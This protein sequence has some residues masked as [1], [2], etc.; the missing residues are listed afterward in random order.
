MK[1]H[2][3][4]LCATATL[5]SPV[6]AQIFVEKVFQVNQTIPDYGQYVDVHTLSEFGMASILDVSVELKLQ[7]AAGSTMRLGDYFVSLTY[8]TASEEERVAVLLNRPRA[9]DTR[10]W[11]SSLGS[12]DLRFD[13]SV[14]APNVFG[15]TSTT[16]TYAADGRLSVDPYASPAAYNAGAVTHGLASLN[17][18][19]LAS[20]TWSLLV[21]DAW[22]GG[23]GM[24]SSWKL[25]I[26]G[27]AAES[28]TLDPGLGGSIGDV[29]GSGIQEVKAGLQ[30][31][32]KGVDS[33]TANVS[34]NLVLSGGLSGAGH[35]LKNG[36]G[37]LTLGGDSSGFTGSVNLY[38]GALR[39][40]SSEAL[41]AIAKLQVSGSGSI[42]NLANSSR[43]DAPVSLQ[44]Y[45]TVLVLDGAG[46]L[47]GAITGEGGL[48]KVGSG[49]TFLAGDSNLGGGVAVEEGILSV[50]GRISG[51]GELRIFSGAT[52]KGS[53]TINVSTT[54]S[55]T[56]AAG[57]STGT[58]SFSSG[59][60]YESDS[61]LEWEFIN[62]EL[63]LMGS[64]YDHIA[65]SGGN[66]TID[67]GAVFQ[68]VAGMGVDYSNVAWASN[69]SFLAISL[70]GGG[71]ATGG[72]VLDDV[73]A[74]N[75]QTY[76]IWSTSSTDQ[77]LYVVWTPVPEP[78][79]WLLLNIAC[80]VS[81][82]KRRRASS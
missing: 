71:L 63:G 21:A 9:T 72:F 18:G 55:G 41:G 81:L 45:D 47:G 74:G 14:G 19:M 6:A 23:V 22:S 43:L 42:L 27:T 46:T 78:M 2:F 26:T 24:L 34:G 36:A 38:Q 29:A 58:Q 4:I 25:G 37:A 67:D 80:S 13:D 49:V 57:N 82:L 69:R 20:N 60:S 7:G 70:S 12:A 61:V 77:G 59:L 48:R 1:R 52:L 65:I 33:V 64:D 54:I 56:H 73:H 75:F 40:V 62:N 30:V 8:G 11:G 53:G 66:L 10:P 17:G 68:L 16:G 51:G 79:S 3:P 44:G 35:L 50:N 15:I 32:G 31:S 5:V 39:I 76:G 28:G